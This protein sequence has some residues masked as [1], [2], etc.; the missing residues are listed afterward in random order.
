MGA[1]LDA[2]VIMLRFDPLAH[3]RTRELYNKYDMFPFYLISKQFG[4]L[5][6]SS[7]LQESHS[8]KSMLSN[9]HKNPRFSTYKIVL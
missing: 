9:C 4:I 5:I 2:K 3:I 7:L 6:R 1:L 8:S